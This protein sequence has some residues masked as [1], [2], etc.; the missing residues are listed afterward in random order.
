MI[1]KI[2]FCILAILLCHWLVITSSKP[3]SA[4]LTDI[5]SVPSGNIRPGML[6]RHVIT[7][8]GNKNGNN[9]MA[10]LQEEPNLNSP[11]ENIYKSMQTDKQG[12]EDKDKNSR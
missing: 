10:R 11:Y 6:S 8:K 4:D 9:R 2:N 1:S 7:F 12:N 5:L 3:A